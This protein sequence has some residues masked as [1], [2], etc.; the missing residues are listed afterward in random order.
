MQ[1][2]GSFGD[3]YLARDLLVQLTPNNL[4]RDFALALRQ[5]IKSRSK[6]AHGFVILAARAVTREPNVYSIQKIL[7]PEWFRE[8]LDGAS[9]HRFP[10]HRDITMSRGESTSD[11]PVVR[12]PQT[13][14][15]CKQAGVQAL[16]TQ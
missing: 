3:A 11:Y 4:N 5:F 15:R 1:F 12:T 14:Y 7:P 2:S 16:R 8:K 10:G 9:L 13:S 6:R